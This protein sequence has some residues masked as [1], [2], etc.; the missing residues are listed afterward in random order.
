MSIQQTAGSPSIRL[1]LM[2]VLFLLGGGGMVASLQDASNSLDSYRRSRDLSVWCHIARDLLAAAQH[3]AY[4]RGRSAVVLRGAAPITPENRG[5]ID[6]RRGLADSALDVA[7]SALRELPGS[8]Y[9]DVLA[10]RRNLLALRKLVDRDAPLPLQARDA[11]LAQRWFDGASELIRSIQLTTERLVEDFPLGNRAT[12]PALLASSALN[13][14]I[15][16]GIEASYIAQARSA[17]QRPTLQRLKLIYDLRGRGDRLWQEI[18]WLA[19]YSRIKRLQKTAEEVKR[20]HLEV[21]RSLQEQV[22]EE[23]V[24]GREGGS[25]VPLEG[26]TAASL[27]V[28]DGISELMAQSAV[29]ALHIADSQ[30]ELAGG[31]LLSHSA[32]FLS[33]L[34]L[35]FLSLR[36]LLSRVVRPLEQ[37]DEE[38]RRLGASSPSVHQGNEIGRLQASTEALARS[39]AIRDEAERRLKIANDVLEERVRERS[40]ELRASEEKYR[41]LIEGANDAMFLQELD[42]GDEPGPFV[43][44]NELAC[45]QLGYTREE[46]TRMGPEDVAGPASRERIPEAMRRLLEE[47]HA[48][49]E[50]VQITKD[51]RSIPVEVSTRLLELNGKRFL[52]SLVRDITER[53]WAEMALHKLNRELQAFSQCNQAL[54]RADDE[55][56]LLNEICRAVCE[57]VGYPMAWVG[58]VEHDSDKTL[59]PM[60]WAGDEGGHIAGTRLSWSQDS[61]HGQCPAAFAIRSGRPYYVQDFSVGA[62]TVLWREV[63]LQQGYRSGIALPLKDPR[64]G[65]FGVFMIYSGEPN[66]IARDEIRLLEG[67]A[68]DLAYGVSALRSQ[69]ERRQ[70]E[71]AL[72]NERALFMAGPTVVFKWRLERGWPVDYVSSNVYEQFGYT[73]DALMQKRPPYADIVHPDDLDRVANE[74]SA[75]A[76]EGVDS[77]MLTYRIAHADKGYRWID[78]YTT[79]MRDAGG[80]IRLYQGYVLD[81]TER[82]SSEQRLTLLNFAF[83]R[84]HDELFLVGEEGRFLDVNDEACR[85]LNYRRQELLEMGVSD[86]DPLHPAERWPEA[87]RDLKEIG[88]RTF[89]SRHRRSDGKDYPVEVSANYFEHEGQGYLLSL[90]R[91]ITERKGSEQELLR[92]NRFLR[93][94]SR[95]NEALVHAQDEQELLQNTCQAVVE[96]GGF[97]LAWVGYIE[98]ERMLRVLASFGERAEDYLGGR[99][100]TDVGD[101]QKPCRPALRALRS[102]EIQVVRECG[103]DSCVPWRERALAHGYVSSIALPLRD[104]AVVIGTFNIYASEAGGF[105]D[106]EVALLSE[107]ADDLSFGIRALHARIERERFVRHLQGSM[108]ST[109]EA[110]A[111]TVEL[112]DPYTAGH[113]RRVADLAAAIAREAG[114]S[115]ERVQV[116]YLAGLVHDIG[117]VAVPAEI[118][119][120]P[121]RLTEHEMALVRL[122]VEAGYDILKKVDFTWPIATMVLHHHERLDGSGYPAGLMGDTILPEARILAVCDTIEA[123]VTHRPY[124]PAVG[125]D[126]ALEE[127]RRGSGV[128]FDEQVV[129]VCGRVLGEQGYKME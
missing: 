47:G 33:I 1:V 28:L 101:E 113:Q 85:A 71:E 119:S 20:L 83:N 50:T 88:S 52:F 34:V 115:E 94:L 77:F 25:T 116:V 124:R 26:L 99:E 48:V 61:P 32:W 128:L 93:T 96:V 66:A 68:G 18:G 105:G 60:A 19:R 41:A 127:V 80:K 27:P 8:G 54:I 7:L 102:G 111:S 36:Y 103:S 5:F 117:K 39:L 126:A 62:S 31:N 75:Y 97:A 59:R 38:L 11:A 64:G 90:A 14:R 13:L 73:P 122:H 22:L 87:W 100:L 51:G 91:D 109:I 9:E 45:T 10:K 53:K 76:A 123:M 98:K 78:N 6:K 63:A 55:A 84:V 118:L 42:D 120:K 89:E 107:L 108:Q 17:E 43:E 4:E 24:E 92:I 70:A 67:F 44:V 129:E 35:L 125:V 106:Q 56:S 12:P 46:L 110:L 40:A 69:E 81:I 3:L 15:T 16:A 2:T 21:F 49:F 29:E 82:K 112:R 23:L 74:V 86:I 79:V 58:Y 37:V 30:K 121:G 65:V 57:D 95:C 104:G 72:R 114:Y